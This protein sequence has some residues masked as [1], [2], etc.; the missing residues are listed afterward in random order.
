MEQLEKKCSSLENMLE[1]TSQST[2]EHIDKKFKYHEMLIRNQ[3]WK[4][5]VPVRTKD[6]LARAA[7]GDEETSYIYG[8]SQMLKRSTEALRRGDFPDQDIFEGGDKGI[9]LDVDDESHLLGDDAHRQLARR[10]AET[11]EPEAAAV[12]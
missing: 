3:N 5:P 1:S 10:I 12:N 9:Y 11:A 8:T 7:Y 2:K 6:E 4:Y